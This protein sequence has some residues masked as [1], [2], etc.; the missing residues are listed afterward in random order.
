MASRLVWLPS[1]TVRSSR[2]CR[3]RA[4]LRNS[5]AAAKLCRSLNQD[6]TVSPLLEQ[7]LRTDNYQITIPFYPDI[8]LQVHGRDVPFAHQDRNTLQRVGEAKPNPLAMV[9]AKRKA[10]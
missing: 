3:L 1:M 6:L 9:L 5:L 2:P 10:G 8:E 4:R 7:A